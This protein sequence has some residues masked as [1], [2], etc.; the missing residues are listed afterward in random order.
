MQNQ[1]QTTVTIET[2]KKLRRQKEVLEQ[3]LSQ[4]VMFQII[5]MLIKNQFYILFRMRFI[6][7]LSNNKFPLIY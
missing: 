5:T 2:D 3:T 7:F 1:Q 6:L 4:Q